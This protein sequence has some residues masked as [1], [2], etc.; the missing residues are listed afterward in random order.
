MSTTDYAVLN[1]DC[2]DLLKT[3]DLYAER[4]GSTRN[5]ALFDPD[6]E[7]VFTVTDTI[8]VRDLLTML[9]LYRSRFNKGVLVGRED[10]FASLRSL[11]GAAS[12]R[13]NDE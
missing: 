9:D 1:D 2:M 11:I 10:A 12:N 6:G 7:R 4:V 13:S 8:N 5:V 3:Q